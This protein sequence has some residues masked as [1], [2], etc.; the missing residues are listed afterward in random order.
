MWGFFY[1]IYLVF[2]QNDLW[3]VSESTNHL[4][5]VVVELISD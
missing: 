2:H 4:K 1:S 3:H 5:Q